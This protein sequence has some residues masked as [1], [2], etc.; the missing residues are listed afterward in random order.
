MRFAV[1]QKGKAR[2]CDHYSKFG[3][4]AT[5]STS[6]TV[7]TEGTDAIVSV[8]K[9]W[10]NSVDA[11][12]NVRIE[13]SDGKVLQGKLH[14]S[15]S[16]AEAA[17]LRARIIDLARA[18]KQLA[19]RVKD[20]DLAIFA[21]QDADGVLQF[22]EAVALGFGAKNAVYSFNLMARALRHA[23]NVLLLVPATHFYDDFS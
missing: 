2:P 7:D 1:C 8:A 3:Q 19:R 16:K 11:E 6:E 23:L 22:Y 21:L 15:P 18:Y 9:V 4:N 12:R 17:A 5:S 20:A 10:S 13:L 14:E